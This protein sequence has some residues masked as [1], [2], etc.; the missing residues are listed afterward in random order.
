MIMTGSD[1]GRPPARCP[2]GRT[3]RGTRP[4]GQVRGDGKRTVGSHV[5][6]PLPSGHPL[7]QPSESPASGL[8]GGGG[9]GWAAARGHRLKH[10]HTD[11]QLTCRRAGGLGRRLSAM[12]TCWGGGEGTGRGGLPRA[13]SSAA[14]PAITSPFKKTEDDV[15]CRLQQQDR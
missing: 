2:S 4:V 11:W 7:T 15:T 14:T 8:R 12:C 13:V 6:R 5:P 9:G 1:G 3:T 10:T